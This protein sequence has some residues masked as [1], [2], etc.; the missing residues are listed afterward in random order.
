M[1]KVADIIFVNQYKH[2]GSVLKQH[3]FIVVDVDNGE[4]HGVPY[5]MIGVVMGSFHGESHKAHKLSY[6][7]NIEILNCETCTNPDNGKDGY[8]KCDQ[9]YYFDKSKLQYQVIGNVIEE[10][11]EK[12][13]EY[14]N[15]LAKEEKLVSIVD[16]L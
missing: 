12:I 10:T 4:I 9:L 7:E 5:D 3:S 14:I 8:V 11:F 15:D 13:I 16:N 1:C 6:S 2:N